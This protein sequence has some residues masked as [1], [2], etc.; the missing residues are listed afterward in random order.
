MSSDKS[1]PWKWLGIAVALLGLFAAWYFLP[2]DEWVESLNQWV[3]QLGSLGYVVFGLIYAVA[4]VLLFPGAILTLAAGLTFGLWAFP[5]V[6]VS[7]TLGAALAFLVGR[8]LAREAIEK[9]Y[10]DDKR[11][12]AIDSAIE[13]EGWKI[14]GL[15][16]LS[17]LIP[18]NLQNY[19]YGLT[20]I[21]FRH[22]VLAT[23]F[24]IMPGSLM[25]VYF[26]AAG[27]AAL[28]GGGEGEIRF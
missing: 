19:I 24:G 25:Y 4:T 17:P 8:Y 20:D 27:K 9:R 12:K 22:Y 21:N 2:V 26:G 3:K 16:R 10:S 1:F 14:V 5:L 11:F 28:G 6:V 18:F 15:L 23:F 7:A 13:E